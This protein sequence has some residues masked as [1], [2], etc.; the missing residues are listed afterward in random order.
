[1]RRPPYQK[2]SPRTLALPGFVVSGVSKMRGLMDS[3]ISFERVQ[4]RPDV[5]S[6]R[7]GTRTG[8]FGDGHTNAGDA[9]RMRSSARD[10]NRKPGSAPHL[11]AFN[12]QA[13]EPISPLRSAL[14]A[15]NQCRRP[16]ATDEHFFRGLS[17]K[18]PSWVWRQARER[19]WGPLTCQRLL[20]WSPPQLPRLGRTRTARAGDLVGTPGPLPSSTPRPATNSLA[21]QSAVAVR[22]R[23][24]LPAPSHDPAR[25]SDPGRIIEATSLISCWLCIT[26]FDTS[27][28]RIEAPEQFASQRNYATANT[29]RGVTQAA[30]DT[31]WSRLS[32][33]RRSV[34]RDSDHAAEGKMLRRRSPEWWARSYCVTPG[35]VALVRRLRKL[36]ASV[37]PSSPAPALHGTQQ[38]TIPGARNRRRTPPFERVQMRLRPHPIYPA[39]HTP[40][41]GEPIGQSVTGGTPMHRPK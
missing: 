8:R 33:I 18:Q 5:R 15:T 13:P 31:A 36:I 3:A 6:S 27:E 23:P 19:E 7:L 2:T 21:S 20:D 34:L 10:E 28:R 22:G 12:W 4:M 39:G 35:S 1:M 24:E 38:P 11:N 14:P 9:L 30:R 17:L 26:R 40:V 37:P 16:G 41:S 32:D 29:L 25:S